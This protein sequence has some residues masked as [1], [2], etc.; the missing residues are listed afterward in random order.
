M[1]ANSTQKLSPQQVR[2][3]LMFIF[4]A[5]GGILYGY[6]LGIISGALLFISKDIPMSVDEESF[7]V[8]AVFGG[9]SI[10]TLVSG[11]LADKFGRKKMIIAGAVVFIVSVFIIY[12]SNTFVTLL[13]GRLIQG[14]GVGI[15]TMVVPLYLSESM[16][17][18]LRGRGVT[19]FQLLLTLG[20]FMSSIVGLYYTPTGNWRDMFLSALVPGVI[21]A[22]GC[23]F[24]S[25]SPR[26]LA[27]KGDFEKTLKVLKKTRTD[28]E[29]DE[30]LTHMKNSI[31]KEKSQVKTSEHKLWQRRFILPVAVVFSIA[32]LQQLTG[33]N[34]LLQL[35]SVILSQAG[36]R[37]NILAMMGTNAITGLNVVMTVV[38]LF[39]VD[40]LE[41]RTLMSFGTGGIVLA[42]AYSGA[43]F[44]FVNPGT[45]KG[46]MLLCG[47]LAFIFFYAVG[48]GAL[49]WTV[50]SELLPSKVRSGG[51][52]IA[53][54]LNSMA[55]SAFAGVFLKLTKHLGFAGVF[56]LCSGFT[57]AYFLL[58]FFMIPKTK[59]KSLEDIEEEFAAAKIVH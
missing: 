12:Y 15:I 33:I 37:S 32:I 24:L 44:Y 3:L 2:G 1:T 29:A 20:I 14:I 11:F 7:L 43:V 4:A 34:I 47:I 38:A 22:V 53:L 5:L 18:S 28:T 42:M 10:A 49:V 13:S 30:E 54:F 16:P 27:L 35:S 46:Y 23:I 40:K 26:W 52:A 39:L 50:L 17:T 45:E 57:F 56:W 6:D 41:R 36:L 31:E 58:C 48:P 21:M 55:S 25:E 8:A 19:L 59:G 9:G 51:L